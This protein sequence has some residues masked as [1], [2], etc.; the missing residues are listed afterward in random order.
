[1]A[2]KLFDGR[3][4]KIR[5]SEPKILFISLSVTILAGLLLS[6]LS[7]IITEPILLSDIIFDT[8]KIF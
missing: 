7:I 6:R 3:L 4:H 5:F 2:H 1:M 8:A